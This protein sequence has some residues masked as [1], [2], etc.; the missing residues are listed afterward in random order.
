MTTNDD[1]RYRLTLWMIWASCVL[2]V[3]CGV[4]SVVTR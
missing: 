3:V 2:V 4:L 1:P